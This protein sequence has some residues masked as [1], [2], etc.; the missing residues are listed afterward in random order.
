MLKKLQNVVFRKEVFVNFMKLEN[1]DKLDHFKT[2]EDNFF[3]IFNE[4]KTNLYIR[5][6]SI[7]FS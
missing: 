2:S 1:K 7:N 6:S 5:N 3:T 4:N